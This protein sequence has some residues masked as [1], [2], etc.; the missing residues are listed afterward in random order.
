L[1]EKELSSDREGESSEMIGLRVERAVARQRQ[2]CVDGEHF[3]YNGQLSQKQLGRFCKIDEKSRLL[4]AHAVTQ[5]GLSARAYDRVLRI[6]RTIADLADRDD[7][8]ARDIAEAIRYRS[9]APP[10]A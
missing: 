8:E 9:F 7:I 2:R 4:L 1:R 6:A 3:A 10:A 5:L